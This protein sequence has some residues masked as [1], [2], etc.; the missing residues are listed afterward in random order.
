MV[1]YV[2]RKKVIYRFLILFFRDLKPEN[3]LIDENGNVKLIDFGFAKFL[4]DGKTYTLCGTHTYM[5]PEIINGKSYGKEADWW[6]FG[7]ILYQM[8]TKLMPFEGEDP[9]QVMEDIL[10]KKIDYSMITNSLLTKLI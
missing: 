2:H 4:D 8:A 7:V 9:M 3:I 6:A 1:N 10:K 5:S